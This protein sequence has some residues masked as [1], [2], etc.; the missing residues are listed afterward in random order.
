MLSLTVWG[1]GYRTDEELATAF[2]GAG[3][4]VAGT[5]KFGW[6]RTIYTLTAAGR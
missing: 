1:S 6:D 4:T 3:V 5:E 2:A